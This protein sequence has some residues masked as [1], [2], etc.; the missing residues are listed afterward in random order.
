MLPW[1]LR[2]CALQLSR[3]Q[4]SPMSKPSKKQNHLCLYHPGG[5]HCLLCG[6]QGCQ[7]LR[8]L[9]GQVTPQATWQSHPRPGG[10][11]HLRGRQKPNW[12]PLCLSGCPTYQPRRAQRHAGSFLSYFVGAGTHVPPIHLITRDLPSRATVCPSSSS[13]ASAQAVPRPRRWHPFPDPV[14]SMPLGGTTSKATSEGPSS[15]KQWEVPPWNKVLKQSHSEVFSQDTDLVKEARKEYFSRHSYNFTAEGTC[16][17]LEVFKQMA[18][19]ANLLGTSIHEIQ[20]VWMGP[21]ELRQ[22]NYAV[23]SLPKGLKFLHAVPPSECL[24][25]MGLVRI[26]DL[27]ALCHFNGLTHCPWCGKEGQNEGIMVN[28]LWTVHYSLG[29]VCNKCNDCPSTSS[30]T[31][32]HHGWQNCQHSG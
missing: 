10:T 2:P 32:C 29:L 21:D 5:W 13:H 14:D 1:M 26:H 31:L 22:A 28:H 23:R 7:D 11:S 9:S 3:Q 8:G 6:H 4:R 27:D 20:A 17:L 12:L 19:S 18:K 15:S 25:V 30:D 24:K 16:N